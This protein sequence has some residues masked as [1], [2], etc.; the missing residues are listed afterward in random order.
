[1]EKGRRRE[2]E[3]EGVWGKNLANEIGSVRVRFW[4]APAVLGCGV[5]VAGRG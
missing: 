3:G 4:V 2:R 5:C 1:M